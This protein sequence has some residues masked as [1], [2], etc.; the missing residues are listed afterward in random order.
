MHM[1]DAVSVRSWA[2]IMIASSDPTNDGSRKPGDWPFAEPGPGLFQMKHMRVYW[3]ADDTTVLQAYDILFAA[4]NVTRRRSR[5][6]P[7]C[8]KLP[9]SSEAIG[10]V[11]FIESIP[12]AKAAKLFTYG[13]HIILV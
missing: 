4:V 11:F 10:D 6:L 1:W 7:A 8:D 3:W 2:L 12:S 9:L 13:V 5:D